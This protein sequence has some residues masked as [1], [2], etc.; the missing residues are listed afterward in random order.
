MAFLHI[1]HTCFSALSGAKVTMTTGG[2]SYQAEADSQHGQRAIVNGISTHASI[3]HY[4]S[5]ACTV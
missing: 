2:C 1:A 5:I 3:T 4:C